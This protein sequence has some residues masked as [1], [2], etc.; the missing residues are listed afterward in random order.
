MS[1]PALYLLDP[2]AFAEVYGP[3]E[4]EH[5]AAQFA[6]LTP[7]PATDLSF[8]S[9]ADLARVE[10]IFS[11]WGVPIMDAAFL[12]KL[13]RLRAVFHAA[14]TVKTFVT[15]ALWARGVRVTGA[16]QANAIPVAEFTLAQVIFALKHGWQR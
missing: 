10:V 1:L 8:F 6:F 11:G 16:A 9:A 12:E 14:G 3:A 4:Q 5:L 7:A 2:A 15:P 13:P